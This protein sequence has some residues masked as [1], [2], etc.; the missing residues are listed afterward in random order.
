M[1][2]HRAK[3]VKVC[4]N[5]GKEFHPWAINTEQKCCSRSCSSEYNAKERAKNSIRN[6]KH[7]GEM[8]M[9]KSGSKTEYCGECIKKGWCYEW[10]NHYERNELDDDAQ[11]AR[12]V[13]MSYGNWRASQYSHFRPSVPLGM[14]TK[15]GQPNGKE[16]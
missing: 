3:I 6:C 8:F 16:N 7:C 1:K 10:A 13:G 9:R 15:F 11:K 12:E 14:V 4:V 2:P 5:C